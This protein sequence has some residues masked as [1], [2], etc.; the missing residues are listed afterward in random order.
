MAETAN[1]RVLYT[2]TEI[3]DKTGI[4][5]PTLQRYKKL[6]QSRIP[7]VGKGRRQ[8]YPE[9]SVPV[10][11]EIRDENLSKRGRPRKSASGGAA[12]KAKPARGRKAK[13]GGRKAAAT[14]GLLT[15]KEIS[16]T[17]GISYPTL[18]RYVKLYPKQLK[19]K[20]SGRSRRYYPESVAVFEELRASSKRGPS[21]KKVPG[22]RGRPPGSASRTVAATG[23]VGSAGGDTAELEKRIKALEKQVNS[24]EKRLSKSRRVIL[25]GR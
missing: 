21:P 10:F 16:E 9:E 18:S 7:S 1:G 22:R 17:T 25:P 19:F 3:S 14:E 8:R 6:Y 23:P 24:L 2:L 4:S 11:L 20:G 5:M 13:A 12:G 15:L